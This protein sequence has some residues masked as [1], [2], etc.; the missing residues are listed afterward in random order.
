MFDSINKVLTNVFSN[1]QDKGEE[2]FSG[3]IIVQPTGSGAFIA[4]ILTIFL[5]LAVIISDIYD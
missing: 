2:G 3:H 1:N 5:Y 4:F